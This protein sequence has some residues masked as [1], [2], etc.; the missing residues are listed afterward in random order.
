MNCGQT[1][2]SGGSGVTMLI[3][4]G[5]GG[6]VLGGGGVGGDGGGGA[7]AQEFS[8]T[9]PTADALAPSWSP[10]GKQLGFLSNVSGKFEL[11]VTD[12]QGGAVQQITQGG[13]AGNYSWSPEGFR[14]AYQD[15]RSGNLDVFSFDLRDSTEYQLTKGNGVNAHPSWDCGG[16][17]IAFTATRD[18]DPNVLQVPWQGG[19]L[20]NI[21]VNLFSDKWAEWSPSKEIGSQ[22]R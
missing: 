4:G 19:T 20:S 12:T 2:G 5:V 17:R 16:S 13:D 11:Y 22:G 10:N 14:L 18:G 21:T 8:V 3:T 1:A 15:L 7:P 6:G 9:R